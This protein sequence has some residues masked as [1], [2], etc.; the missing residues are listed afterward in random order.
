VEGETLVGAASA[1][2]RYTRLREDLDQSIFNANWCE[3]ETQSVDTSHEL[4]FGDLFSG[5]G[6]LSVGFRAANFKKLFSVE[7]NQHASSTIR[8]N[9]PGS[10]HFE[11]PIE[12]ITEAEVLEALGGRPLDV[13]AG[14]PP[15]QGFSVAGSRRIDDPRNKLF[16]EF[17]RLVEIC[18]PK[19]FV[20]ENVP[21][22]LTMQHGAV[23]DAIIQRFEE[24]G[25]DGTTVRVLEAAEHGVPQ[26]RTR[27]IFIGNRVGA[28][29][30]YPR[31]TH[32]KSTYLSINDAIDDLKDLPRCAETNHEW[33]AHSKSFEARIA[34]VPPGGSLYETYRDAF[35]RQYSGVPSM[36]AKENHGGTHIHYEKNRVLS[37]RELARL[38]TF[39]DDFFFEGGMKKA[40]WQIGNAVPCLLAERIALAL[41]DGVKPDRPV[42]AD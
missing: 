23:K 38:Q 2:S 5:A 27:A 21:G 8:K 24:I 32:R 42:S 17:C 19:F 11:K 16:L 15:C 20:M 18:Q 3:V 22:I 26:L 33:T 28:R 31:P 37:A 13:L 41:R 30:P 35:K 10:V 4:T 36:A 29:N 39:P 1:T 25:Y 9:F 40:Y 6:G 34:K 7:I 12:E 14:G